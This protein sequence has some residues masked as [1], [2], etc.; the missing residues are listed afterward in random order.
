MSVE[1]VDC[2]TVAE[3]LCTATSVS[4]AP[5]WGYPQTLVLAV[6]LCS[7]IAERE[8]EPKRRHRLDRAGRCTGRFSR[9][10]GVR[11]N[12]CKRNY[13]SLWDN[14][15]PSS[16]S[17]ARFGPGWLAGRELPFRVDVVSD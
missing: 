10:F 6:D 17:F 15:C 2:C 3:K 1:A 7:S 16:G 4:E 12:A 8:E 13:H 11:A 9:R 14:C 5:P